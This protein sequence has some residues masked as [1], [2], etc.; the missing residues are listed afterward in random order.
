M[1]RPK[2]TYLWPPLWL[3]LSLQGVLAPTLTWAETSAPN[4]VSTEYFAV[5]DVYTHNASKRVQANPHFAAVAGTAVLISEKTPVGSLSNLGAL[6]VGWISSLLLSNAIMRNVGLP[7]LTT[8]AKV[9]AVDENS[10]FTLVPEAQACAEEQKGIVSDLILSGVP[11]SQLRIQFYLISDA[12]TGFDSR[13]RRFKIKRPS[14][15]SHLWSEIRSG[16]A[17]HYLDFNAPAVFRINR[18]DQSATQEW[19]IGTYFRPNAKPG[20]RC[21]TASI[22][23]I[24]DG[25]EKAGPQ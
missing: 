1:L 19:A 5:G 21:V 2:P 17:K 9:K 13:Q 8:E 22:Q 20:E 25:L 24:E 6:P 18:E 14:K 12:F 4:E 3:A 15:V 16:R 23:E 11:V 7:A 10:L